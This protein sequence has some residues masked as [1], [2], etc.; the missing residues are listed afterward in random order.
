MVTITRGQWPFFLIPAAAIVILLPVAI[1]L[2]LRSEEDNE[3]VQGEVVAKTAAAGRAT[4]EEGTVLM[5]NFAFVPAEVRVRAGETLTFRS[6]TEN[7]HGVARGDGIGSQGERLSGELRNG[8][9]YQWKAER[10]GEAMFYCYIHPN[11]MR[12]KVT[13]QP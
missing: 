2:G 12:L 9:T 6:V 5:E 4:P 8:E 3:S 11:E 13:V 7:A 10:V 1:W